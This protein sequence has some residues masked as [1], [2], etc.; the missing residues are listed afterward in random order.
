MCGI[1]GLLN[2]ADAPVP[3]L[4]RRLG[5]MNHLIRH[6]GPDGEGFWRHASGR[7]GFAHRRLSIIDLSTGDQPMTDGEGNWITYNGETYN[8]L[9]LRE[10][11]GREQFKTT[12]DTE[13]ILRAYRKWGE[14][15]VSH[16]RGMFAFALW[17]ER[18]QTLFCARDRFGIKP[19]YYTLVGDTFYFASEV[20]ALLPF[21]ERIETDLEGLRDYLAFQFCLAGKTLF[22]NVYELLPGHALRIRNGAVEVRRYW[23]VYYELDFD[24]TAKYFEERLRALLPESVGLHMR[25]DVPV[26]TYLSGGLDSSAVASLASRHADGDFLGFTGKFSLGEDYDESRYARAMAEWCGFGL[27]EVDITAQDFIENIRKVIYHLDYPVAGPGSFPQYMVSRL[28]S[29]HRKVVLGG[30]GGDEIFGGYIRYLIAYFEQC[31]KAAIDGTIGNGN[32]VV[33]Y[34]SIIPNLTA[35]HNYRPLLQEF[36]REGLFEDMDS[37][38]FRLINRAPELGGEINWNLLGDYSPFETFKTVFNGSNVRQESYFDRMTHFDFKTLLPALLQVEDRVSMAHGLES[39]V[40]LLDHPLVE[41]AATIPSN[42]KFKDGTMKQVFKDAVRPVLPEV[43]VER[44][45]KM[46]FPT[47]LTEWL[48]GEARDFV[49]DVFSSDVAL[50]RE[51][52]NNRQ[53]LEGLDR[54]PKF[55]RKAWGLLCLELWQQEF[56]DKESEYRGLLKG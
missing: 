6:R 9:E 11:L 21:V 16:L 4:G 53:V 43:I 14:D 55:G 10:E 8:Y 23:E 3:D 33:T 48:K 56:H 30:Q 35:L 54:E 25:A 42:I 7:A 24:H 38:Y 29:R 37:R 51:L 22:K 46:G 31:I 36:W 13:V 49:L 20:K 27:Y 15:C 18:N 41:F 40:P 17:D 34:E 26:G 12:S 47:P 5:V 28:A 50:G 44:K 1:A 2:L 52:F 32:Y 45:D 19:F 39:R